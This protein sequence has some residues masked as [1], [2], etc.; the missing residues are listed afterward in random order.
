MRDVA[1]IGVGMNKWGELWEKSLRNLFVEAALQAVDDAGVDRVDAVYVGC[2]SSGLFTAQEH[3]ASMLADYLGMN[4]VP[5]TRVE[6]ACASGGLAFRLGFMDVASGMSDIVLV[7]G[8]EKMN[9]VDGAGATF[10]LATAA[11]QE[12]EAYNGVTFPGLYALIARAHM[13]KYGTTREQ[14]AHVAVKNHKNGTLNPEA[15]YRMEITVDQVLSSPGV[16]DPLRLLDCSPI[17]D[18]AAAVLLCPLDLARK[19]PQ[20]AQPVVRLGQ[21]GQVRLRLGGEEI[22]QAAVAIAPRPFL[23]LLG[24]VARLHQTVILLGRPGLL[25]RYDATELV[26]SQVLLLQPTRSVLGASV[27]YLAAASL[28]QHSLYP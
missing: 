28:T 13:E 5:C 23:T 6:S 24:A 25:G 16:A 7:G 22:E 3:L 8:V 9:D 4:P 17:T 20:R 21:C 19:V 1:V 26:H 2:M 12:Y 27:V 15:Q 14:L 11:D 18:G 10:A